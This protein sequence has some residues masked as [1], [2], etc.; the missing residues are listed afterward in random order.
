MVQQ[1]TILL[2]ADFSSSPAAAVLYFRRAAQTH[3]R[4]KPN[5]AS[6]VPLLCVRSPDVGVSATLR[7]NAAVTTFLSCRCEKNPSCHAIGSD[8]IIFLH[9]REPRIAIYLH[10]YSC[11]FAARPV[12]YK[13]SRLLNSPSRALTR[14]PLLWMQSGACDKRRRVWLLN[15]YRASAA[16]ENETG[17]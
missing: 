10:K 4:R 11:Y 8:L 17:G 7:L 16:A 15:S 5:D 9:F 13:F 6:S 14:P 2:H 3:R 12:I 1:T